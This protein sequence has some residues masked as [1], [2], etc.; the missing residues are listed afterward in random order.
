VVADAVVV[1]V[2]EATDAEVREVWEA[3]SLGLV[4]V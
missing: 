2:V 1:V 4:V 3:T